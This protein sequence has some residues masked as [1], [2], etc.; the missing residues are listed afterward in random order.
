MESASGAGCALDPDASAHGFDQAGRDSETE[1]GAAEFPGHRIVRL[2]ETFEDGLMFLGWNAHTCVCYREM[3]CNFLSRIFRSLDA[4]R[5]LTLR[6]ELHRIA[7]QVE[8]DLTQA[9][10]ISQ[11][12]FWHFGKDVIH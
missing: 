12:S 1:S 9:G 7:N 11:Q 2:R 3:E 10:R 4:E 6:R 8:D 5:N